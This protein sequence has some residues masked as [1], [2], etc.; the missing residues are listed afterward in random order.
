MQLKN[1]A[2]WKRQRRVILF[3]AWALYF[4][5]PFVV[6]LYPFRTAFDHWNSAVR[7]AA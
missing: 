2:Q 1:W 5:A 7:E 4:I 3:I 6:Y